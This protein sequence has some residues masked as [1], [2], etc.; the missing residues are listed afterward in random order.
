MFQ[1]IYVNQVYWYSIR[2]NNIKF[3]FIHTTNIFIWHCVRVHSRY[4]TELSPHWRQDIYKSVVTR[5]RELIQQNNFFF[6]FQVID[7]RSTAFLP[8][9]WNSRPPIDRN[10]SARYWGWGTSRWG[11]SIKCLFP[12]RPKQARQ[13]LYILFTTREV[14]KVGRAVALKSILLP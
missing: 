2:N 1:N 6:L 4:V 11:S 13:D 5:K 10:K 7:P 12:I 9:R 8:A 3:Y 14:E